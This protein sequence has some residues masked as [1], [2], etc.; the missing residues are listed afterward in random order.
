M[1]KDGGKISGNKREA[2][3]LELP[4]LVHK[5]VIQDKKT[6]MVGVRGER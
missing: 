3:I 1:L 5:L 4:Q 2:F 6:N